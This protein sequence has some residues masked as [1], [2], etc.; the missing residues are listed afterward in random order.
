MKIKS[1]PMS[2]HRYITKAITK[3]HLKHLKKKCHFQKQKAFKRLLF[4]F[5]KRGDYKKNFILYFVQKKC[6]QKKIERKVSYYEYNKVTVCLAQRTRKEKQTTKSQ[7]KKKR[8]IFTYKNLIFIFFSFLQFLVE[9][10]LLKL[11]PP[12]WLRSRK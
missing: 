9:G 2:K 8:R 12:F 10:Y 5:C 1:S 6:L 3:I 4:L 7:K 11:C